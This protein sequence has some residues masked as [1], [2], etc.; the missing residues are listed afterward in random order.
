[1][2]TE[3]SGW[4]AGRLGRQ[5][6]AMSD[7]ATRA[8]AGIGG[9]VAI[10]SAVS[11]RAFLRIFGIPAGQVTGAAAFGWRLF[12]VRTAFIS[13]LAWRGD[14]TARRSFLPVQMLDQV[15]FWHAFATRSVPRRASLLAAATSGVI[16]LLDVVRRADG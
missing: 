9:S 1:M 13:A 3:R 6:D 12:A 16:V 10:G 2:G 15:V 4:T 7:R 14:D 5:T 11:P 8:M